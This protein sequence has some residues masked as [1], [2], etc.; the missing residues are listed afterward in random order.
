MIMKR[1]SIKDRIEAALLR[2][3]SLTQKRA[4]KKPY[5]TSRLGAFIYKLRKEGMD[6]TTELIDVIC[7]DNHKATVAKYYFKD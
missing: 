5:C 3:E 2:G 4:N 7:E 6:I 1:K